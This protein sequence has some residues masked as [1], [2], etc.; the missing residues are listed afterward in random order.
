M[1]LHHS[2]ENGEINFENLNRDTEGKYV[3]ISDYFFYLGT[4]SVEFPFDLKTKFSIGIGQKKVEGKSA[5]ILI[6][7]LQANF[8][9]GL[10]NVPK[11]F[12]GF[13]RYDGVS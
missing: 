10:I 4:S 11:L 1:D 3:L 6:E 13:Q 12:S 5:L 9:H 7:W 8:K 2:K